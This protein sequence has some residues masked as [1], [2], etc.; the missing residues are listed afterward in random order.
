MR[1]RLAICA[2]AAIGFATSLAD[3]QEASAGDQSGAIVIKAKRI[4][5]VSGGPIEGGLIVIRDGR[6]EA[7]GTDLEVPEGAQIIELPDG[8]VTPGL[9]DAHAAINSEMTQS[10]TFRP[11]RGRRAADSLWR[12]L[13]EAAR[14]AHAESLESGEHADDP[15]CGI[16]STDDPAARA[17]HCPQRRLHELTA[18]TGCP[19]CGYPPSTEGFDVGL[20]PGAS[21]G[22]Q[23]MEIEPHLSVIDTVNLLS[24]D[25]ERLLR[26]GVTTV[27]V[28]PDSAN[29]VCMRGAI[30]KTG[31]PLDKRVV[32]DADAVKA[33]MGRDAIMR[34]GFNRPPSGD[35][36]TIYTR[37]P[38]TRMGVDWVFRKAFYDAMRASEG[39]PIHGADMPPPEAVP[40][41]M[42]V[43]TGRV[44]LRMQ[45]RQQNDIMSAIRLADE[46]G[47]G[48]G[49]SPWPFIL[50]EGT[51][52]YQC[53]PALKAHNIPVVYGPIFMTPR[54]FRARTGETD[55]ARLNAAKQLL[56]AGLTVAL[57][58]NDM[59]DEEGLV[60]QAM[61]AVRYGLTPEQ[62]LRAVTETP[63]KLLGLGDSIGTLAKGGDADLVVWNAD[64]FSGAGRAE[65]VMIGGQ[66][67]YRDK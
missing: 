7:L 37:R 42:D 21:W 15:A 26:G 45:A 62:A 48:R 57:T 60:R 19:I 18:A 47:L 1:S 64:P 39:L 50:E 12:Q 65:L 13:G 46:F 59:R 63:A 35:N 43:I 27:W 24:N 58:A 34:G 5:P 10:R 40:V 55:G 23:A 66:V 4:L 16:C 49:D 25:F 8:I 33:V 44:P 52:A 56:D 6:I 3:A 9:I 2:A 14:R 28:S 30:V 61:M 11:R 17:A 20:D 38:T 54:G 29:V 32:R 51:E 22:E 67:V 31:G 41:L 53:I 36:V